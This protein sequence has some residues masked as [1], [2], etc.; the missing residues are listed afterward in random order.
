MPNIPAMA[1]V[2]TPMGQAEADVISG[3]ADPKAR[4]DAAAQEIAGNIAK[5]Q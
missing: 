1:S 4:F 3:T 2:W 5:S